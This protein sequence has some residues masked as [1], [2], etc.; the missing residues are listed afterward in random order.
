MFTLDVKYNTS[1][2]AQPSIDDI[3]YPNE[4]DTRL[5]GRY[6]NNNNYINVQELNQQIQDL[7]KEREDGN[8][9]DLKYMRIDP[10]HV[11]GAMASLP[12]VLSQLAREVE[13]GDEKD[14]ALS[15]VDPFLAPARGVRIP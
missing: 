3:G 15:I 8:E 4:K 10:R 11:M 13:G 5:V 7:K 12:D 14:Y 6:N 9:L 1:D 2:G